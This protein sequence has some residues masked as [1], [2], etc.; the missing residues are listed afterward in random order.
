MG[1]SFLPGFVVTAQ[2]ATF[3]NWKRA[4]LNW[5][6]GRNILHEDGETSE[7]AAQRIYGCF[8]IGSIQAFHSI[9]SN[10]I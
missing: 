1:K 9:L 2:G 5:M 10:L 3:L 7:Q 6:Y 8:V 4:D